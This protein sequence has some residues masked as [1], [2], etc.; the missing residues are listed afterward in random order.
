MVGSMTPKQFEVATSGLA[1]RE[2]TRIALRHIL[3]N[4]RTWKSASELAGCTQS[5]ISKALLRL[6]KHRPSGTCPLCGR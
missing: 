3:V 2:A 4:G 1:L 6:H 5:G